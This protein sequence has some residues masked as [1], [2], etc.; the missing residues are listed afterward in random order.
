MG[1]IYDKKCD[2]KLISTLNL[3][4]IGDA[5]FDL[6][7]REMLI[8]TS[9]APVGVLNSLKIKIVCCKNQ[10]KKIKGILAKL[11]DKEK[12]VFKRGRNAHTQNTPK[13]ATAE[14]YH[15]ATGLETLFGY[16]YLMGDIKRLREIFEL[17]IEDI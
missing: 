10:S 17:I 9:T 3:A 16:I 7:V 8:C 11:T 14:E 2:L 4:F 13:N 12:S 1:R 6:M 15:N 5:V